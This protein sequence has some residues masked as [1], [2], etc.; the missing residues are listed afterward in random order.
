MAQR[1]TFSLD[2]DLRILLLFCRNLR[3]VYISYLTL[4]ILYANLK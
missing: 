3:L 2:L 4:I 1:A